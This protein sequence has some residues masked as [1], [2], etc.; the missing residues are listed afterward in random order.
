MEGQ[1]P[2]L[3]IPMDIICPLCRHTLVHTAKRLHC[4]N[5][6]SFDIAKQGYTNLLPVHHKKSKSPGDDTSMVTARRQFLA[7]GYYQ[8]L[9]EHINR[10]IL[11]DLQQHHITQANIID[12]GCG[13]GYYTSR[14]KTALHD[15]SITGNIIG[16]D[17][18]KHAILAAAKR[19]QSI[20]WLVASSSAIPTTD[21]NKESSDNNNGADIL[22]SL[23]APVQA[24][25]FHRCLNTDGL[26]LVAS[27]GKN[28][29][30]ELRELLYDDIHDNV[31][32]PTT[33]ISDHFKPT[34][35]SPVSFTIDLPD[36]ATIK[37][38]FA[39]TPHY[40]RVS[41]ER[42]KRL[43]ALDTLCI[44]VDIQLYR[45]HAL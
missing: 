1:P 26:L 17:I 11:E 41:P 16:L 35:V 38:L 29:L 14:L 12:A 6:H 30:I 39:M 15:N 2:C 42:K 28:H 37:N 27:T 32:D 25:E 21:S 34:A 3:V 7:G 19:D 24:E 4:D 31:F 13:E 40:W 45:F 36:N 18:S 44:T 33:M 9:S 10:V 8:P 43:D 5:N 23:F 22:L 20:R